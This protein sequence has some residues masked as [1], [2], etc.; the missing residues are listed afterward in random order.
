M[1]GP[2]KVHGEI[3]QR[4]ICR[5][6]QRVQDLSTRDRIAGREP[7]AGHV[8]GSGVIRRTRRE[9]NE[10]LGRRRISTAKCDLDHVT[11]KR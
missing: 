6:L 5:V 9:W 8:P 1:C 2:C 11:E 3:G 4:P 10:L 7:I